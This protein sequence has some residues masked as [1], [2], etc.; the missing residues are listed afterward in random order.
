MGLFVRAPRMILGELYQTTDCRNH[1]QSDS[2][3]VIP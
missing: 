3:E 1:S 2:V